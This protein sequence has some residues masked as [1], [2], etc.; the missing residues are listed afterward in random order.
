MNPS[1]SFTTMEVTCR[2]TPKRGFLAKQR[3]IASWA[4]LGDIS[5]SQCLFSQRKATTSHTAHI[6]TTQTPRE[7]KS[8]LLAK[9]FLLNVVEPEG[10]PT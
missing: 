1:F 10:E 4:R 8:P 7:S 3:Q 5:S 9:C 6:T 2:F